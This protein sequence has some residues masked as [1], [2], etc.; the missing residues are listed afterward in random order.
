MSPASVRISAKAARDL[1]EHVKGGLCTVRAEN[2]LQMALEALSRKRDRS[3][4]RKASEKA[5]R[6]S[7]RERTKDVRAAVMARAAE[8][9]RMAY[10]M[11]NEP[12]CENCG[13]YGGPMDMDHMRG[14][15]RSESVE[16]C[17]ALCGGPNGCHDRKTRNLPSSA[18]WLEAFVRH[19]DKHAHLGPEYGDAA[20]EASKRLAFVTTRAAL[21]S[22]TP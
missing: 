16:T 18:F 6:A 9:A 10:G 20:R 13:A 4:P 14:R 1:L 15:A 3:K 8:W 22:A 12:A 17:W 19:C 11:S 5:S 7:K 2:E 21:G